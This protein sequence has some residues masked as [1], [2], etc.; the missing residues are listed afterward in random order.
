MGKNSRISSTDGPGSSEQIGGKCG[1]VVD[2]TIRYLNTDLDLT[3]GDDLTALAAAFEA[4]VVSPLDVTHGEDGLWYATFETDKQH[5]QP[6][7][8]IAA[9]RAVIESLAGPLRTVWS[10]CTRREFN[11]GYACGSKPWAFNQGLSSQ[12]L[13]R[14]AAVGAS[15]RITLYPPAIEKTGEPCAIRVSGGV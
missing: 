1:G 12:L 8:N 2:D 7:P 15:Q 6:D 9:I 10:G 11:I 14:M 5:E 3:S 13:G 4:Q